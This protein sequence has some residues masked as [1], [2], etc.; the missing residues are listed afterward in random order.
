MT[1]SDRL[2]SLRHSAA[3]MLASVV[4]DRWPEAQ[5][6]V[7][8]V[9]DE[10]FYYDIYIPNTTISEDDLAK[11]ESDMKAMSD[12]KLKFER[13][14]LPIDEATTWAKDNNQPFKL[15]LLNDLGRDGTTKVSEID[16]GLIGVEDRASTGASKVS[17]YKHGDFND[18]CRGPHVEDTSQVV[19]F[20]LTKLAGA[21]WRGD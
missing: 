4:Q 9:V 10:G 17:F 20:K 5:F 19:W 21:Y 6:G 16:P 14:E 3:H 2:Y 12:K 13:Y 1:Q 8:P 7:G 18:L 15:E 11:L